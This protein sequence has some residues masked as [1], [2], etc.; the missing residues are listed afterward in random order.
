MSTVAITA[1]ARVV[2]TE[3]MRALTPT[4]EAASLGGTESRIRVGI[5][6]YPMPTPA[7]ATQQAT[8]SCHGELIRKKP[9]R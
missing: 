2:P 5:A 9:T 4:A 6:A 7:E 8:R 3:R 1:A